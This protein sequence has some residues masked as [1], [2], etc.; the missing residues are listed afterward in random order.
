MKLGVKAATS[1]KAIAIDDRPVIPRPPHWFGY[2]ITPL[3]IEFW[4]DRPFR[5]HDRIVFTRERDNYSYIYI[6]NAFG[7]DVT[8]I[9]ERGSYPSWVR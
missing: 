9:S 4:H 3:Q 8:L 2:R 7:G 6:M 1:L 5:L